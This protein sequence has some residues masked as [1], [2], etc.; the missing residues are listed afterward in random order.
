MSNV[1][2]QQGT[3][4]GVENRDKE[5]DDQVKKKDE[6]INLIFEIFKI[7]FNTIPANLR[8]SSYSI[9]KEEIILDL[10][11]SNDMAGILSMVFTAMRKKQAIEDNAKKYLDFEA[12]I[13]DTPLLDF[14]TFAPI[15]NM[16]TY[17]RCSF[18][19]VRTGVTKFKIREIVAKKM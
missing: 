6:Q 11:F 10:D 4:M 3:S 16:F 1:D 12:K 5:I 2:E 18:G 14:M 15:M 7:I 17:F 19:E 13:A 9:S 8:E